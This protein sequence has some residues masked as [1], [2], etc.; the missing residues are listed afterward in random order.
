MTAPVGIFDSGLGG[1]SVVAPIRRLL[2]RE[3]LIYVADSAHCPYGEKPADYLRERAVAIS[4]FLM[5][6]SCK[7]IV[8]ACNT[9]TVATVKLLRERFDIP[10]VGLEPAVKPAAAV[11][12]SGVI[13]VL[14]TTHTLES[15]Q[16]GRLLERH[17]AS[18]K[19]IGEACPGW[20]DAVEQGRLDGPETEAL[21]ERHVRPL[22][23]GGADTLVLGCT[24]YPFLRT[25]IERIAGPAVAV[26]DTGEPVAHQLCRRLTE[27]GLLAADGIPRHRFFTSGDP[28]AAVS[29]VRNAWPEI[30]HLETLADER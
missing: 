30:A 14:A 2:P 25:V 15:E 8:V 9:A 21:V 10:V 23:A 26:L 7:A 5:R 19:V 16:F 18:L 6:Q 13:G 12:R 27:Q 1:L 29:F 3:S 22:L 4:E 28:A 20:V 11:T 24:H 17:A